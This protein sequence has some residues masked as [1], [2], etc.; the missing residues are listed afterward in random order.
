MIKDDAACPSCQ[1]RDL[2]LKYGLTDPDYHAAVCRE[3]GFIFMHPYPSDAFLHD[4]YKARALYNSDS[5]A[6][7]YSRAVADRAAL[8]DGLLRRAGIVNRSGKAVD[9]GAGVGI[10]VAAQM[11]MGFEALGIETNPLAQAAGRK[12]FGADIR[13]L[14]LDDMPENLNLFTLFEVLEHIKY[15]RDFLAQVRTHIKA[16]GAIAGSVPNYNS[17]ARYLRGKHSD[18]LY[19]PEHVNMFTRRTLAETLSSAGF[20]VVYIG[21]PPPYGVVFTINLR[22]WLRKTLPAAMSGS[23]VAVVTWIKKYLAYPLPN[24]FAEKTGLLGHGLV[25]IARSK[26]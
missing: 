1:G 2:A 12:A 24:W 16:G 9:F 18:A 26:A 22:T 7:S 23:A 14:S 17:Y 25:F 11:Q 21:F 15:P 6:S 10:A 8:I 3:C 4:H 20:D 19:W 13:D 5:D